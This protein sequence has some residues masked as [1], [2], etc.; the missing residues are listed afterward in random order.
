M[1]FKY[2]YQAPR[3]KVQ[4]MVLHKFDQPKSFQVEE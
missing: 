1:I 2:D 3:F 4:K